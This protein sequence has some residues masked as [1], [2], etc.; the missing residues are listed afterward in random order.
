MGILCSTKRGNCGEIDEDFNS[1]ST[2]NAEIRITE[3]PERQNRQWCT[4]IYVETLKRG[5]PR[6]QILTMCSGYTIQRGLQHS[7]E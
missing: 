2:D 6:D 5:K 1:Q 7:Y 3:M 4:E